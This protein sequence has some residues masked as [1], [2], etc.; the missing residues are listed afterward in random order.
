MCMCLFFCPSF[1]LNKRVQMHTVNSNAID[2]SWPVIDDT[3][4][5]AEV[6][7]RHCD[8]SRSEGFLFLKSATASSMAATK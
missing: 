1:L 7:A 4:T 6:G 2:V 5:E 8:L 3:A